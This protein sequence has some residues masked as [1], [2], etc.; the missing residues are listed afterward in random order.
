MISKFFSGKDR[1]REDTSGP[2]GKKPAKDENIIRAGLLREVNKLLTRVGESEELYSQLVTLACKLTSSPCGILLLNNRSEWQILHAQDLP[3]E[4]ALYVL[5]MVR[6]MDIEGLIGHEGIINLHELK[7][8]GA[9]PSTGE[10]NLL[11]S[12]FAIPGL[13]ESW[14]ILAAANR[15]EDQ[16]YTKDQEWVMSYM[17]VMAGMLIYHSRVLDVYQMSRQDAFLALLHALEAK[18]PYVSSRRRIVS[19]LCANVA[20]KMG[21]PESEMEILRIASQIYD[22]GMISVPDRILLKSG[23]LT[24]EEFEQMQTHIPAVGKILSGITTIPTEVLEIIAAH[25]ERYDGTGYPLGLKGEDIPLSS[26]IIHICQAYEA[27][28]A[29]RPYRMGHKKED[30]LRKMADCSGTQFDPDV[31]NVFFEIV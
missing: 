18:D 22:V 28:T 29:N 9:E 6:E 24:K 3:E 4:S 19:S 31:L 26:R 12:S 16:R 17:G 21:R 14:G 7:S 27:L 10:V 5:Q 23:S 1:G 11:G 8:H 25:H 13:S 2:E 30:A 20:Q 15:S